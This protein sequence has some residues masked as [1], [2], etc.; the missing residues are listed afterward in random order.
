MRRSDL[1]VGLV[2]IS[3]TGIA[4]AQTTDKRAENSTKTPCSPSVAFLKGG[5]LVRKNCDG[6]VTDLSPQNLPLQ[7]SDLPISSAAATSSPNVVRA[8]E[9]YIVWSFQQ[10][11]TLYEW[12]HRSSIIIFVLVIL[13]VLSGI[14]FAALQFHYGLGIKTGK[15]ETTEIDA[16]LKGF[17][18]KSSLLGVIVLAISMA[19]LYLYLVHIYPI[20]SSSPKESTPSVKIQ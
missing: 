3:L 4:S 14:Y 5:K 16:S 18:V 12:Q 20:D 6:S 8:Q 17:K 10:S 15:P 1:I 7:P 19:F 2:L 13:L 11:R 9:D